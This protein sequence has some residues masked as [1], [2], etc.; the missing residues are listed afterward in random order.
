MLDAASEISG[1]L[2]GRLDQMLG[3]LAEIEWQ[4][5]RYLMS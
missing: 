5:T 1:L 3:R 2:I 4:L